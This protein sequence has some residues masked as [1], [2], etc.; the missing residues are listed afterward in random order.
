MRSHRAV[1]GVLMLAS[2]GNAVAGNPATAASAEI[3]GVS[4][5]SHG[6]SISVTGQPLA[7]VLGQLARLAGVK[8]VIL[9]HAD[10]VITLTAR[11]VPLDAA[12]HQLM[13]GN[14]GGA[15]AFE[16]Q[17][18]GTRSLVA[19]YL[20]LG[21]GG[22]VRRALHAAA[23]PAT[24]EAARA[25]NP[26]QASRLS[27]GEADRQLREGSPEDFISAA[28]ALHPEA[29]KPID[30]VYAT[31]RHPH[32]GVRVNALGMIAELG[33]GERAKE[34]LEEAARDPDP[35]VRITARQLLYGEMPDPTAV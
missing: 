27:V 13:E 7:A 22:H 20:A 32:P 29:Q 12:F 18:D 3:S 26:A 19:A 23:A 28:V 34:A 5:N 17:P 25:V 2:A 6:V 11:D 14:G 33:S 30:A 9:Q 16:E 8:L 31:L 21:V 1:L 35:A 15:L 4:I 10:T 24:P